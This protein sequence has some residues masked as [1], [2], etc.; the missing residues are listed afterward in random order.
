MQI[1]QINDRKQIGHIIVFDGDTRAASVGEFEV[2]VRPSTEGLLFIAVRPTDVYIDFIVGRR[3]VVAHGIQEHAMHFQI[4]LRHLGV[5]GI[6]RGQFDEMVGM[7]GESMVMPPGKV[8]RGPERLLNLAP[9]RI[10][11]DV[12]FGFPGN[13]ITGHPKKPNTAFFV[14]FKNRP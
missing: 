6:F 11:G 8:A 2:P 4:A 5:R 13:E 14:P 7:E 10:A 1:H 3:N 12:V 9:P